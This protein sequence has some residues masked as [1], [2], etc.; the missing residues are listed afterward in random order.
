VSI[1]A[2]RN[3]Q[4]S[5]LRSNVS[6]RVK[7]GAPPCSCN[8]AGPKQLKITLPYNN[9]DTA[10]A[11]INCTLTLLLNKPNKRALHLIVLNAIYALQILF[12]S[13]E[14]GLLL[15]RF[16]I[17]P[18]YLNSLTFLSS[19]PSHLKS[20]SILIYIALVFEILIYSPLA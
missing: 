4:R 20:I 16:I 12:S 6:A 8:R 10:R 3:A 14:T 1:G 7:T 18:K 11:Y 2:V 15:A 17:S 13:I 5:I 19:W 9:V